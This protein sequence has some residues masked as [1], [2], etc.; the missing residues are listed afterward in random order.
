MA[1]KTPSKRPRRKSKRFI[2][3]FRAFPFC[4]TRVFTQSGDGADCQPAYDLA[5]DDFNPFI[6]RDARSRSQQLILFS[7]G[8]IR[9][10][11]ETRDV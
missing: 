5:L 3:D 8:D 6:R 10:F 9:T 4:S 7:L 11:H 1:Q 2:R